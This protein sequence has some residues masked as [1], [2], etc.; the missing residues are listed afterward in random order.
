MNEVIQCFHDYVQQFDL[1]NI[2]LKRKYEHAYR[3]M[4]WIKV[5]AQ[6]IDLKEEDV[7]L[8]CIIGLLHD[9]GRFEQLKE[10]NTYDDMKFEH[11][12]FGADYLK[13]SSFLEQ[14]HI[15]EEWKMV[16]VTATQLHNKYS[17]PDYLDERTLQFVK[18]IRDADK[19]DIMKQQCHHPH[20]YKGNIRQRVIDDFY[21]MQ[22]VHILPDM[23][24]AEFILLHLAFLYDMNYRKSIELLK[25]DDWISKYYASLYRPDE[26]R[27]YFDFSRDYLE[28]QL[29]E[30][31]QYVRNKI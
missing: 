16:I 1:N 20:V 26:L 11:A 23:S 8:S 30:E 10:T 18:L 2:D 14:C 27:C 22:S 7:E 28:Q 9:I 3:V 17:I 31:K 12:D 5:L 29:K 13:N 6:S 21:D 24:D 25:Q 4:H 19:I 15:P